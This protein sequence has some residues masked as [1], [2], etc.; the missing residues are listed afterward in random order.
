MRF[1]VTFK[2]VPHHNYNGP[3]IYICSSHCACRGFADLRLVRDK[4]N[5]Q[6]ITSEMINHSCYYNCTDLDI[7]LSEIAAKNCGVFEETCHIAVIVPPKSLNK[8]LYRDIRPQFNKRSWF[9]FF[10]REVLT[11]VGI[12]FALNRDKLIADW[13]NAKCPL[14]WD[15]NAPDGVFPEYPEDDED[16]C[17]DLEKDDNN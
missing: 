15:P 13:V 3:E 8:Y 10:K 4:L 7:V 14:R 5:N 16:G 17:I 1:T 6:S 11:E 12:I 9:W 2:H